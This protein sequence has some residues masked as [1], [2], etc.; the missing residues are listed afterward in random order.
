[1][2]SHASANP[3]INPKVFLDDATFDS[4]LLYKELLSGNTFGDNKH[5]FKTY[6]P[7]NSRSQLK[8]E[9]YN[10]NTDGIPCC[11][12]NSELPLKPEGSATRRNGLVHYKFTC[13]KVKWFKNPVTRKQKRQYQCEHPCTDSPSGRMLYIY[14]E[15]DFRAYPGTI[16][17]TE[18]WNSTYKIRTA[19]ERNIYHT[20]ENLCLGR[21]WTQ[22]ETTLHAD[23]I[24][25]EFT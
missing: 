15:K 3:E 18:E 21:R 16:R 25:A 20:K 22:N 7:L 19:I 9:Y 6:I 17:G 24:L 12:K 13:P 1:M 23:L 10:I 11:P 14:P 4:A 5:F 8:N 2:L